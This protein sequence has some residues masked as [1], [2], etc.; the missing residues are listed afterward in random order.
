MLSASQPVRVLVVEDSA[1][2][3]TR[4]VEAL[5][6]D[7]GIEVVAQA[8]D[9]RTAID[10]CL[11]LRPDVITMAV[12]LPGVSGLA[13]TEQLMQR[14][15]T[16]IL[17]LSA[18]ADSGE[19]V[20]S[21]AALAA[22]AVDVLEKPRLGITD[23][24]DWNRRLISTVKL[25]ARIQVITHLDRKGG[26]RSDLADLPAAKPA[27]AN[28]AAADLPAADLPAANL[29]V[30]D[31]LDPPSARVP[32]APG[33]FSVVAIG[34][35][36]GGPAAVATVLS[37]L[38]VAFCL[39]V[40]LVLHVGET[41]GP[42]IANW[43][44]DVTG[45]RVRLAQHGEAVSRLGGQ[46][47]MAPPGQHLVVRNGLLQLN[48]DRERYSCRPS[49]DVLFESLADE[50]GPRVAACLLTGMG[51]DGAGGLL[52]IHRSG[53]LTIAQDEASSVVFGMPGEAVRLGAAQYVLP[54]KQIGP[55]LGRLAISEVESR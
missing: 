51:K 41:F 15:P 43:L 21:F 8:G 33:A 46:V 27:A 4:I 52:R 36:T 42:A 47:I 10:L 34:A 14:C 1:R 19:L 54:D 12:R 20:N 38:P 17:I 49:V 40:L 28:L 29:A 9:G 6:G 31:V 55:L 39:P 7:P 13:A 53:G 37:A 11:Q 18:G 50:C 32:S 23:D 16:P 24:A 3:R 45:R 48:T 44:K 5:S 35:S 30:A 25:V 2:L 22:G 26:R